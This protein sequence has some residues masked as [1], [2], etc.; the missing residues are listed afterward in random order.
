M[1]LGGFV[2]F[3]ANRCSWKSLSVLAMSAVERLR[4]GMVLERLKMFSV[5]ELGVPRRRTISADLSWLCLSVGF[6]RTVKYG[7]FC[8]SDAK[9]LMGCGVDSDAAIAIRAAVGDTAMSGTPPRECGVGVPPRER[10]G[11]SLE[12]P[13]EVGCAP[14]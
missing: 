13:R 5:L 4:F 3:P 1:L 8:R 7:D 9:D 2:M 14:P 12:P 10:W 11:F 6:G